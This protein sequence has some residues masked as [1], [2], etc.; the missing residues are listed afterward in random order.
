M[1]TRMRHVRVCCGN[2]DRIMGPSP[3]FHKLNRSRFSNGSQRRRCHFFACFVKIFLYIQ[4]VCCSVLFMTT[5][6]LAQRI[7]DETGCS[8][9]IAMECLSRRSSF[10]SARA[11]ALLKSRTSADFGLAPALS[12]TSTAGTV[13]VC[14]N[15][16]HTQK[17][18]EGGCLV[19][20]NLK[21]RRMTH[22]D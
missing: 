12:T 3:T 15:P 9:D 20:V 7:T 6:Q 22:I 16:L 8:L 14:S 13:K 5:Q 10:E 17:H 2:W 21:R 4:T 11:L 19:C 18:P 1:V